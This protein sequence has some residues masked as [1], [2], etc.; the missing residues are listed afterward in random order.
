MLSAG[1]FPGF[2]R[3]NLEIRCLDH[4]FAGL[5]QAGLQEGRGSCHWHILGIRHREPQLW[6]LLWYRRATRYK[7]GYAHAGSMKHCPKV[8]TLLAKR[9]VLETRIL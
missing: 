2:P 3:V 6:P 4:G 8:D 5:C 1:G 9:G 7:C